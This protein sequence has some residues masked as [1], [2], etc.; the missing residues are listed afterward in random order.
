[1]GLV[2]LVVGRTELFTENFFDPVAAVIESGGQH[3]WGQLARLWVTILL[4]NLVGGGVLV[5]VMAV[6]GSLPQGSVDVL[7]TLADD[8]AARPWP[9]TVARAVLAGGIVLMT[10]THSAQAIGSRRGHRADPG[11]PDMKR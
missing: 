4:L 6:D 8:I 5:G 1:M 9:A 7:I 10:L 2:F 11:S 3:I